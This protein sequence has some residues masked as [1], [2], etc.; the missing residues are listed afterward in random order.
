MTLLKTEN[1]KRKKE[2][3]NRNLNYEPINQGSPLP[4]QDQKQGTPGIS[5]DRE[6]LKNLTEPPT[7]LEPVYHREFYFALNQCAKCL[8]NIVVACKN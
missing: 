2:K 5:E 6:P 7:T 8:Y 1:K 4:R 3:K